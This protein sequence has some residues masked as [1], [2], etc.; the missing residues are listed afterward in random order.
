MKDSFYLQSN[1]GRQSRGECSQGS[2]AAAGRVEPRAD[3]RANGAVGAADVE[4][5]HDEV[6][7][8]GPHGKD[9]VAKELHQSQD[10]NDDGRVSVIVGRPGREDHPYE[11][12][13][14]EISS[15]V[16]SIVTKLLDP[17]VLVHNFC[18]SR[19][20]KHLIYSLRRLYRRAAN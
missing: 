19:S 16:K 11:L 18:T 14:K 7:V 13:W 3:E 9:N 1:R 5:R 2:V 8:V 10:G 12:L 17:G 6:V 20:R 4:C 15:S